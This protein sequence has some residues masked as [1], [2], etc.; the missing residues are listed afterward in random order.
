[1]TGDLLALMWAPFLMCLVLT[2]IHAY[3]G[4]HVIA[5]E[6]VFV[7]IA[8]AQ[9]AGLGATAGLL[10]GLEVDSRPAYL[11]ALGFTLLGA[12]VLALTRSPAR[13]VSQEAVIGVV[14]AVSAGAAVL[15][16]DRAPHGTEH[17]RGMLVGSILSVRVDDVV[18]VALLY[19]AVGVLHWLCRRPFLLISIDPA[20]A[21][22]EG[23]RVRWWDFLFYAS[24]ALVVTS[25]VRIA[26]VLLVFSYLIVPALA[27]MLPGGSLARR[28]LTGWAFGAAVSV[29]AMVASAVLDLPTGATVVCAFGLALVVWWPLAR[30]LGRSPGPT[31][32]E[33]IIQALAPGRRAPN[34]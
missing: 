28:L 18:A 19:A 6:V 22:R 2:G 15:L 29:M 11:L 7:D 21:Y 5:R 16:S 27:G 31:A 17:L 34:P 20:A 1:M 33:T 3:L 8:L 30:V 12:L 9:I 32:R 4:I 25:S 24:F 23:W 14:Y 10:L 13:T 26:G